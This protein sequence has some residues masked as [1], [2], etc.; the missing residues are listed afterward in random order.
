M[1]ST[2]GAE[3]EHAQDVLQRLVLP[4]ADDLAALALYVEPGATG[5]ASS[6]GGPS[7]A[8]EVAG[9]SRLRIPPATT[10]SFATYF[11]GFPAA[12]WQQATDLRSVSL[13][14]MTSGPCRVAVHRSDAR[15]TSAP[16]ASVTASGE[17]TVD[18]HLPLAGFD[19]GGWYWFDV[20]AEAEDV[21]VEGAS[22][23]GSAGPARSH[24][25]GGITVG[26]T[27]YNRPDSALELVRRLGDDEAVLAVLD[28]VVVVDQGTRRVRDQ[29]GFERAAVALGD[30]LRVV[31]Q[32]N[33]GG[34]GGFSRGML[35]A[36]D[37]GVSD[38]VLL[39]DDDVALEPESLL[40]ALAFARA[41]RTPTVVGGNMLN[42]YAPTRLHSLGETVRD[43]PFDWGPAEGVHEDHDLA[44]QG[45]RATPWLHRRVD[46]D[47]NGWW[48]CLIPVEVLRHVGLSLP[49]FIK[50]DDAEFGLRAGEAGH[51][52]VSLPG[53]AIWHMPWTH[54]DELLEWQ[55]Y[56]YQRNRVVTALLHPRGSSARR[57]V[58]DDL[59]MQLRHLVSMQ[60]SAAE[61]RL[62]AVHDILSGPG[63]LHRDLATTLPEVRATRAAYSD[64]TAT[65]DLRGFSHVADVPLGK[66]EHLRTPAGVGGKLRTT[67]AGILRQLLPSPSTA[68]RAQSLVPTHHTYWW[69]MALLDSALV[70]TN[71]GTAVRYYE[72]DRE[73]FLRLLR[74]SADASW[75][76][77]RRW[78]ALEREYT[79]ALPKLV[80]P[81]SWRT[82]L[83][84]LPVSRPSSAA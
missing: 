4:R 57:I 3:R 82:T 72:R 73:T 16:V 62:R 38:H 79:Q 45:L 68:G 84:E 17:R 22:W 76:L 33:V 80:A 25:G 59:L 31:E 35:E 5:T 63:H 46:V 6:T 24:R 13:Q 15:G 65:Q 77:L 64:A 69:R 49:F 36:L 75:T 28:A 66:H 29:A 39:L 41:C 12:H 43:R 10:A 60:Y 42:L 78:R 74:S 26:V 20:T 53:M 71:D 18:F 23:Q 54:K 56:Y 27:T 1:R 52:T 55:G 81:E 9:R 14:V 8:L 44:A 67:A 83:A 19:G 61:L 21:I 51:P 48:M 47:Y 70:P 11:N 37:A 32:A 58:A 50:W 2:D 34:S 40:R 30:R 7:G